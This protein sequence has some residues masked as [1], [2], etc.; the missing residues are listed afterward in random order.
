M[1]AFMV[2]SDHIDALVHLALYGPTDAANWYAPQFNCKQLDVNDADMLGHELELANA[3]SFNSLYP[4]HRQMIGPF[5]FPDILH[6]TRP[7]I[8]TLQALKLLQCFE[9]QSDCDEAWESSPVCRFCGQLK[10]CLIRQLAGYDAAPW[11]YD[12]AKLSPRRTIF[13]RVA[14]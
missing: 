4:S 5:E 12:S 9:Y 7:W 3:R 1:S 14:S 8:T 10:D 6:A 13:D 11:D 2:D